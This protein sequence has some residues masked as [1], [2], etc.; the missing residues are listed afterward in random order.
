M[1]VWKR[2]GLS[3]ALSIPDLPVMTKSSSFPSDSTFSSPRSSYFALS[4]AIPSP[5]I[6]S[7]QT[8]MLVGI[9]LTSGYFSKLSLGENDADEEKKPC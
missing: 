8:P 7:A 6:Q 9:G 2:R 4:A 1:Q 5:R 3:A